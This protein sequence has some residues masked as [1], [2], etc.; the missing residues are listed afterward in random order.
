[1]TVSKQTW[2]I[3]VCRVEADMLSLCV[4]FDGK[5]ALGALRGVCLLTLTELKAVPQLRAAKKG[6]LLPTKPL[7][8]Q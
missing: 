4:V 7:P 2:V 1:M 6:N 8:L 5:T 3:V